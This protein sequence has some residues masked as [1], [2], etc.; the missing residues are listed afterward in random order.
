MTALYQGM[1]KSH[2]HMLSWSRQ[3]IL[4]EGLKI[5]CA[6]SCKNVALQSGG[7]RYCCFF[8]RF[9]LPGSSCHLGA[10]AHMCPSQ[11]Q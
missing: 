2:R 11:P 5:T 3:P 1:L 9:S 6:C 10:V 7:G 4:K 8:A